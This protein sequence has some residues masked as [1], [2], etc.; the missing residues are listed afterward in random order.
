MNQLARIEQLL[1][2]YNQLSSSNISGLAQIYHADIQFIDPV[3]AVNGLAELQQHFTHSYSNIDYCKFEKLQAFEQ[4]NQ[5]VL[6][7][8]MHFSHPSIGNSKAIVVDGCSML[9]WQNDLIIYHRDYYDL[10]QMVLTHLPVIGWLTGKVKQ[11]M[12]SS[13]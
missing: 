3:K 6:T 8:K 10:Q 2:F 9:R 7:W 13:N 12:A 5:G 4:I 11:R 1:S